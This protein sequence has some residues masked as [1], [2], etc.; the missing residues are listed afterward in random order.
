MTGREP[1]RSPDALLDRARAALPGRA[2][3][4]GVAPGRINVLGEH[5]DYIGGLALPTAV[6]RWCAVALQPRE[7]AT[8]RIQALDLDEEWSGPIGEVPA[9]PSWVRTMAGAIRVFHDAHPLRAGFEAAVT[10][11]VPRGGGLSS[12]A[13]LCLAWL[14]ALQALHG[15]AF[16]DLRLAR[17]GQQV[18]HQWTGVKC[19]LLDQVASQCSTGAGLLQVDFRS[20]DLQP[21]TGDLGD[22][23]WLVLDTGV[24]REL[25]ASAYAERVAQVADGLL[26]VQA[27]RPVPDWRLLREDDLIHGDLLDQRLRH[28]VTENRRVAAGARAVEQGDAQ[29]LGALLDQSHRSL[30]DDYGVSCDELDCF[31]EHARAQAGCLGA[32]M[33]GGG[34]GGCA[35]ALVEA[36]AAHEIGRVALERYSARFPHRAEA[37]VVRPVRGATGAREGGA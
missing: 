27:R 37:F 3:A 26:R 8:L 24:R 17:M 32:R 20:L 18:E 1:A 33:M 25:A 13:A 30:R 23:A 14:N 10:G 2:A 28:G 35:L 31:V 16:D 21:V 34:F 15:T 29:A 36:D 19:G 6:D 5:T 11:D 22:V 4:T 12:S 9:A 7:D